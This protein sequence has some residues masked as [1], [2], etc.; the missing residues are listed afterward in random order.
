VTATFFDQPDKLVAG[1]QD[2]PRC[3]AIR[4]LEWRVGALEHFDTIQQ[5]GG[6]RVPNR[7]AR[8][9]IALGEYRCSECDASRLPEPGPFQ[10]QPPEPRMQGQPSQCSAQLGQAT[11]LNGP[12]PFK[13]SKRLTYHMLAWR[14]E[15]GKRFDVLSDR[16][17]LQRGSGE[18]NAANLGLRLRW[19]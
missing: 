2:K 8:K 17:E 11:A 1:T 3:A 4:G 6:R 12:K 19:P 16:Q 18:I 13:Q 14:V 5:V 10:Q 15:P 9:R 7:S